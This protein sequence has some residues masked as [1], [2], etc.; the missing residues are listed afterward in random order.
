MPNRRSRLRSPHYDRR[1]RVVTL[2]GAE[3]PY[4]IR[5][6]FWSALGA[7]AVNGTAAEPGPGTRTVVDIGNNITIA[8]GRLVVANGNLNWAAGTWLQ[9]EA[10]ARATGLAGFFETTRTAGRG[11]LGWYGAAPAGL[12]GAANLYIQVAALTRAYD[13][14]AFAAIET[15]A[16]DIL[17]L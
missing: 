10:V 12:S 16:A 17:S 4:L 5:D 1:R 9:Y 2:G 11:T 7:G 6:E 8:G 15:L 13:G 14:A 3:L